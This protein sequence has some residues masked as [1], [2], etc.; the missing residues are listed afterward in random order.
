MNDIKNYESHDYTP[1]R[2]RS[3]KNGRKLFVVFSTLG[4]RES[5]L[6]YSKIS[7]LKNELGDIIDKFILSHRRQ[8][9]AE[10]LTEIQAKKADENTEI[11]V[12]NNVTVP[13]MKDEPG[14]GADMRRCLYQINNKYNTG[15][16]GD[17]IT[18][19]LDADVTSKY[20]GPHFVLG[21]AGAVLYGHDFAKASFWRSMGRVKKYVAQPLFSAIEHPLIRR[22]RDFAYPLSGEVAGTLKFFNSVHFWQMYGVET[23]MNI[24]ALAGDFKIADVN[25]GLYDHDHKDDA[26]IQKMSFGVIRTFLM[27]LQD[28]GIIELKNGAKISDIFK[29]S[30]IDENGG[31][32]GLE[33][34]L[35][36]KKYQ[37]LKNIL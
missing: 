20:F 18:V 14:K 37:P 4:N 33:F 12:C 25:L 5:G 26:G 8:I 27:Q 21:L 7:L 2:L 24:D 6:I 10:E 13:D 32:Q 17:I 34:D 1:G 23:G 3:V 30:F 16:A 36:E 35:D 28:S 15:N 29:A 19:F 22:L 11:I 9:H 31:R